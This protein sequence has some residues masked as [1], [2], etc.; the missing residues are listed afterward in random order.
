ML[1]PLVL[2]LLLKGKSYSLLLKQK[3]E[4]I[5]YLKA[6]FLAPFIAKASIYILI[7]VLVAKGSILLVF[8]SFASF[9]NKVATILG[10]SKLIL[11][12]SLLYKN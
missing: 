4:W 1:R 3:S 6:A 2:S 11:I 9:N 8:I 12:L 5:L 10:F 7:K